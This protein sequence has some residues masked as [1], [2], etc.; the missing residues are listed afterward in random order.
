MVKVT[1]SHEKEITLVHEEKHAQ[2]QSR[3]ALEVAPKRP[4]PQA[5]MAMWMT[6][7]APAYL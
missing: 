6:K 7:S 1:R 5:R 3:P 2:S 4:Q